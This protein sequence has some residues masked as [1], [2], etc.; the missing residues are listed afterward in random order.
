MFKDYSK[1]Q[2]RREKAPR[3]VEFEDYYFGEKMILNYYP[4]S[5][6]C[7]GDL[8]IQ[9]EFDNF[10]SLLCTN[11][12][13]KPLYQQ[14]T[15]GQLTTSSEVEGQVS[16]S[17]SA[18]KALCESF[19]VN[20]DL[21]QAEKKGRLTADIDLI[22][23]FI[24]IYRNQKQLMRK[25]L[26]N[27]IFTRAC[28]EYFGKLGL[29]EYPCPDNLR[30]R[31]MMI[32]VKAMEQVWVRTVYEKFRMSVSE[33]VQ[34]E[35]INSVN[36]EKL[37]VLKLK[38]V[39]IIKAYKV[40]RKLENYQSENLELFI[41]GGAKRSLENSLVFMTKL[42]SDLVSAYERAVKQCLIKSDSL[43]DF[44]NQ[45]K[46]FKKAAS[47]PAFLQNAFGDLHLKYVHQSFAKQLHSFMLPYL[48][49]PIEV[50]G[51]HQA[52]DMT[53]YQILP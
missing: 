19:S 13:F 4:Y 17:F 48:Q 15:S 27:P 42:Q 14:L 32:A 1:T 6:Q 11:T 9:D 8:Q 24:Q 37:D 29:T 41:V 2:L 35:L 38:K 49:T 10:Y 16:I 44:Q 25:F 52:H 26:S 5:F 47:I 46:A 7:W 12:A 28:T 18:Y 43:V 3:E 20:L 36:M 21:V 45:I 33:A 51:K 31:P 50:Q 23:A 39:K 34:R 22:E 30:H 53:L 40:L